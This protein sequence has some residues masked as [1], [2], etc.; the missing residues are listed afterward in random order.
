ML[1][2]SNIF[3][4]TSTIEYDT[5]DENHNDNVE[6]DYFN[7]YCQVKFKNKKIEFI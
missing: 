5:D 7:I 4:S 6:Q 3:S 2:S 1:K